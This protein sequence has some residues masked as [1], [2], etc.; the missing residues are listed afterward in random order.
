M[1]ISARRHPIL[2]FEV[3]GTSDCVLQSHVTRFG[4]GFHEFLVSWR[5]PQP[6]IELAV[7]ASFWRRFRILAL[8]DCRGCGALLVAVSPESTP[9][10][11]SDGL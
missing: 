4:V 6:Y 7:R 1:P 5:F 11:L 8:F 3:C 9:S 2:P 10:L